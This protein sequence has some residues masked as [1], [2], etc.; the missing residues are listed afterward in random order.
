MDL[1]KLR[2]KKLATFKPPI[3]FLLP[4]IFYKR[5]LVVI[6]SSKFLA[7]VVLSIVSELHFKNVFHF[8]V[9]FHVLK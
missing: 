3:I 7:M 8:S 5:R 4:I 2:H 6:L 1:F 9:K